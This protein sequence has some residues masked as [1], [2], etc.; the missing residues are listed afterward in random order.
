MADRRLSAL[1]QSLVRVRLHSSGGV[2]H[3]TRIRYLLDRQ[4]PQMILQARSDLLSI[5]SKI[6]CNTRRVFHDVGPE[7]PPIYRRGGHFDYEN[8][9]HV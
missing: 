6:S 8:A 7:F 4:L 2:Q 9:S 1:N 3:L 5:V